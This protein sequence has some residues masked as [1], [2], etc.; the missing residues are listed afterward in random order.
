MIPDR[1]YQNVCRDCGQVV[2]STLKSELTFVGPGK[3]D[4][5]LYLDD[6]NALGES[7]R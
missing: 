1:D 3:V 6:P 4:G 7:G 5:A 2:Q